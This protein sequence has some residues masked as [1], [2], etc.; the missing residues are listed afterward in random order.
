MKGRKVLTVALATAMVMS[1]NFVVHADT[2]SEGQGEYEG[3]EMKYPT[4]S[5]TLPTIADG[6][7]DYIADPNGLIAATAA[8]KYGGEDAVTFTG[9]SGIFFLT[10][11]GDDENPADV[12]TN[13]SAAETVTNNNA[14]DIDVTVKLEQKT[15]G[16]AAIVYSNTATFEATDTEN[17][18]YLAVTDNAQTNPTV[19]ALSATEPAVLKATVAGVPTNY[20]AAWT[21]ENGYRYALKEEEDQTDWNA[22]SFVLTGA[23]NTNATWGD[24]VNFPEIKITWSYAEHQDGIAATPASFNATTHSAVISNIPEGATLTGVRFV[25]ADGTTATITSGT[26]YSWNANTKTFT[27]LKTALDGATYAGAKWEL[28]FGTGNVVNIPVVAE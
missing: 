2:V 23:L 10:T 24:E 25:K 22:C 16:D 14:Q 19:A 11:E 20:E 6:T 27:V 18:L 8:A 17:K 13:T 7:Y 4:L 12:Y 1:S 26:H 28:T 5:V 21:E 15:A 9:T 3:G